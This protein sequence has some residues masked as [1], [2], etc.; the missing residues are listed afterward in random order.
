[1][2]ISDWSHLGVFGLSGSAL[3]CKTVIVNPSNIICEENEE[4]K[5][6]KKRG[7]GED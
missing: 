1:M 4:R 7:G 2:G 3:F 6:E 5:K